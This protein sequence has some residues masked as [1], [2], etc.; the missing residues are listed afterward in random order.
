MEADR[1]PSRG[2]NGSVCSARETIIFGANTVYWSRGRLAARR[3]IRCRRDPWFTR[4]RAR[5]RRRR[6]AF[7]ELRV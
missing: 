6:P 2:A 3:A 7:R 4:S 1:P 5:R